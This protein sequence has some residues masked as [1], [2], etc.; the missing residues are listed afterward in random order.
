VRPGEHG[1][2]LV[3]C[4]LTLAGLVAGCGDAQAEAETRA[5]LTGPG[6]PLLVMHRTAVEQARSGSSPTECRTRARVL[7][8]QLDGDQA[9]VLSSQVPD[10][11]LA[12][13]FTAER[14]AL[15]RS[16]STCAQGAA[17]PPDINLPEATTPV[18]DRLNALQVVR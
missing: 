6:A 8:Q 18:E 7:Q 17:A 5:F 12:A 11:E 1:L 13:G 10:E 16:L 9:L 2:A 4:A 14:S 15:A 3:T